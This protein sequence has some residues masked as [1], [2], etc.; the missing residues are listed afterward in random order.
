MHDELKDKMFVLELGW[1][2]PQSNNEFAYVPEDVYARAKA[3][4]EAAQEDED[5]DEDEDE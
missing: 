5:E 1:V 2:C 3:A 4:A